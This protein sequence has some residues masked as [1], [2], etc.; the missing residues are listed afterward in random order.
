MIF[1]LQ[2]TQGRVARRGN[3]ILYDIG[4][5]CIF[6]NLALGYWNLL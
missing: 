5:F 3:M 1:D 2:Y 6:F 4:M